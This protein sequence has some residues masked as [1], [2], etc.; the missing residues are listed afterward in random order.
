M[1]EAH[2][3]VNSTSSTLNYWPD[4]SFFDQMNFISIFTFL[5]AI[6]DVLFLFLS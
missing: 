5:S 6:E 2:S 4:Q 3:I 1:K